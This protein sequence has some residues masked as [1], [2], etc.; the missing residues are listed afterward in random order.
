MYYMSLKKVGFFHFYLTLY[1]MQGHHLSKKGKYSSAK[2][3][4]SITVILLVICS[5]LFLLLGVFLPFLGVS[6][7]VIENPGG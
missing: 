2:I 5:S 6:I 3:L 1:P 4:A 7:F